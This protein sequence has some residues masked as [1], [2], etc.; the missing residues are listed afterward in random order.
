MDSRLKTT[1]TPTFGV[2]EM[3]ILWTFPK[4]QFGLVKVSLLLISKSFVAL[5]KYGATEAMT[6]SW[7]C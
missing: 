6:F 1:N 2:M 3:S 7:F 4:S 5:R